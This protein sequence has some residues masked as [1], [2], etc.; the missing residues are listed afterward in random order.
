MT[1]FGMRYSAVVR[2]TV[3]STF[4]PSV[5]LG[6]LSAL[7]FFGVVSN[8]EAADRDWPMWR[9]GPDRGAVSAH[10]LPGELKLQW[11][12]ELPAPTPAWPTTQERLQF[13]RLYEPVLMGTRLYVPSMV[14]DRV[15]AYDTRS[16]EEVWRF[17]TDAPVRFAPV[18]VNG[19]V[20]IVSDDGYLYALDGE[21]G[22]LRWKFRGGP[23]DKRV[24]GQGRLVSAWVARGAPVYYDGQIYFGASIWPFMG[25]FIHSLDA[26]T[27]E[28]TWTN[29]GSGADYITQQHNSPAFSGVAPQGYLAAND[30]LLVVA[31]GRTVPAVYDR[32]TGEFK[33]YLVSP[34][35]DGEKGGGGYKVVLGKNFYVARGK[36]FRLDNGEYVQSFGAPIVS[37]YSVISTNGTDIVGHHPEWEV[38]ET[39]DRKGKVTKKNAVRQTWSTELKQRIHEVFLQSG[40]RLYCSADDNQIASVELPAFGRP[41]RVA[42]T[43]KIPDR[44][45]N[46]IS[47]DD[48]L[49]VSTDAGRIYC[50]GGTPNESVLKNTQT[51]TGGGTLSIPRGSVWKYRDAPGAPE[52][53][54]NSMDFDDSTWKEGAGKLGYGDG[55]ERTL[56]SFGSDE[57]KK[58]LACYF[59]RSFD[60]EDPSRFAGF[61]L[62]CLVDDGAV[63]YLNGKEVGRLF[64]PNGEVSPKTRA[65]SGTDEKSYYDVPFENLPLKAGRNVFAVEVHQTGRSSSD[66]GFDLEFLA[67]PS[68][69]AAPRLV[70]ADD[71]RWQKAIQRV[72]NTVK[73]A[74]GVAVV[75]GVHSGELIEALLAASDLDVVVLESDSARLAEFRRQMDDLGIYGVR[76]AALD[77]T[78]AS[79]NLP[80]YMAELVLSEKWSAHELGSSAGAAAVGELYRILRPYGGTAGW[81]LNDERHGVFAERVEGWISAG[82]LDGSLDG[83]SLLRTSPITLLRRDRPPTGSADWTHQ[84]ADSANTVVSNDSVV[85]A[86]LGLLWFGGPSNEEVLPRH[87]HGPTPHVSA[88]RLIIEG[89]NMLRATDIYTGRLLWQRELKDLGKFYDYT[90]HEPGANSLGS[91]YVSVEDGVYVAFHD[92]GLRLDPATGK[93]LA[94]FHLHVDEKNDTKARW[95][96]VGVWGDYLIAGAQPTST[97]S[98]VVSRQTVA[99]IK[100]DQIKKSLAEISELEDFQPAPRR[101]KQSDRAYL[102]VNLNRLLL[103]EH[104]IDRIPDAVREK[105]KAEELEGK[106]ASYYA[107]VPGRGP[108]DHEALMLKRKLL[109]KYYG[110]PDVKTDA[111]GKMKSSLGKGSRRVVCLNRFTGET[112]W[113]YES[114]HEIRHNTIVLA[115][116]KVFLIDRMSSIEISRRRRRGRSVDRSAKLLAL[117][118][119]TG[120]KIWENTEKIF[121]TWMSYSAEHDLL[122]EA[123]SHARDRAKDEARRGLVAYRGDTGEVVWAIDSAYGGPILLH[124]DQIITQVEGGPGFALDI[125]TG[126]RVQRPHP[127]S[128]RPRDW[129]WD[130]NYGCNTAIASRH[131]MTF[132]SA[133]A[134][135]IDLTD[136]S[137]TGNF[138]GFR[139]GCT[140][141]LIPAGGVLSAPDY[142]R[143]CTCAYQNQ[144]SLGLVHDPSVEVW[145]FNR[146]AKDDQ[147]LKQVG[148]NFG[149]P[150]DR[151]D[152]DG[153]LWLDYPSVGGESPDVDVEFV[154]GR[155][156]TRRF[157]A[158]ALGDKDLSWVGA[159]ALVGEGELLVNV[160][161]RRSFS[162]A[163]QIAVDSPHGGRLDVSHGAITPQTAAD[164]TP[165]V[166]N[167]TSLRKAS[168]KGELKATVS[169]YADLAASGITAELLAFVDSDIDYIDARGK[170]KK[171]G[172]VIDNRELRLR[173]YVPKGDK[174]KL[175]EI[176]SGKK[177]G[178]R[179]WTHV[180]FTYD[181]AKGLGRLYLNGEKVGE[182]DGDDGTPLRW[183]RDKPPYVVGKGA[184]GTSRIDEIRIANV[185]LAPEQFITSASAK[186]PED[187]IVGHWRMETEDVPHDDDNGSSA[188]SVTLVFAELDDARPGERVYDVRLQGKTILEAFD[189][190]VAAAGPRKVVTKEFKGVSVTDFLRLELKSRD[191]EKPPLL[192]GLRVVA[193]ED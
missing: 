50:Y 185:A 30:K 44:P 20:Y 67:K 136:Y 107:E 75:L 25:I 127:L 79:G 65:S 12:L 27:G 5:Q 46:M 181:V 117:D 154:G 118:I 83:A 11:V 64:M 189:P 130:R 62:R 4:L 72:L 121:G 177:I 174:E 111:P 60:V 175:I 45:L 91:N 104:M 167:R 19:K 94:E 29:S 149:A 166:Q 165:G 135:Y 26:E 35:P 131:L 188:F 169:G 100:D 28:V 101:E 187:V 88:G 143:T 116:S 48:R 37:D 56:L 146:L 42:W 84:N 119:K 102:R 85:R 23:A 122:F 152:A 41:A 145:T 82:S 179:S 125:R 13:D 148:L 138:G 58:P 192:S 14:S 186:V 134:G 168:G 173:Y 128:L 21:T 172:F 53:G 180:A 6:L 99:E 159:S 106:L 114:R 16:G 193:E 15:T 151:R 96:Y 31:G 132:R 191:S 36:M 150:G 115:A 89:R 182:N 140:S 129:T 87:G 97:P 7:S 157:H 80:P 86:P 51:L 22:Q 70:A 161:P 95:G 113:Q 63:V 32:L 71:N 93:T 155:K 73:P 77:E 163:N 103:D 47:G 105:A 40:S 156:T 160:V 61:E 54:W 123:G 178:D 184:N 39:K 8:A 133:A 108:L 52:A 171:D 110:L 109:N 78:L 170:D 141:N 112:L 176:K 190:V 17:Y 57:K 43:T 55:D 144:S 120:K 164:R 59:R 81:L 153:V 24:L 3:F 162:V 2:K 76:V 92:V 49:F 74:G 69:E 183:T 90:S 34:R 142:T 158:S 9:F 139:S 124:G 147:P 1:T 137:G 66:L 98:P 33:H 38:I 10:Q 126:K 68:T 18:A